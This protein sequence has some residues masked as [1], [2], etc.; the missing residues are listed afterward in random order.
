MS[1]ANKPST[2]YLP[3]STTAIKVVNPATAIAI[4]KE[5]MVLVEQGLLTREQLE[6]FI[7]KQ[8]GARSPGGKVKASRAARALLN[9]AAMAEASAGYG[10]DAFTAYAERAYDNAVNGEG[11]RDLP[12][13][14]K[15][16]GRE[17]PAAGSVPLGHLPSPA[18]KQLG[19]YTPKAPKKFTWQK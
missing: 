14:D 15:V 16:E 7:T 8:V 2:K 5:M 6:A 12:K 13:F 4:P 18:S 17:L 10:K 1:T 3:A 19:G 9:L 11:R